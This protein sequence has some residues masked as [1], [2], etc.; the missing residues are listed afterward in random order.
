MRAIEDDPFFRVP[1]GFSPLDLNG[2]V[3]VY[4]RCL[5]HWRQDGATY[6]VTVRQDDAM[7]PDLLRQ[8]R[9]ERQKF[10]LS[11]GGSPTSAEWKRFR[12]QQYETSE[13]TLDDGYG[14]CALRSP[15]LRTIVQQSLLHYHGLECDVGCFVVMPNHW[16]LLIRPHAG[17]SL[18][19]LLRRIK[20]YSAWK[21][22]RTSARQGV[23]WGQESYDRLVRDA[24][25]LIAVMRYIVL[26]G[27]KAGLP[28]TE[29][30]V[31]VNPDWEASGWT[32]DAVIAWP[33]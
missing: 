32:A 15:E 22:N 17:V 25:H 29:F 13:G 1:P 20:G 7:P 24:S 31:W 23:F 9:R 8:L 2:E 12:Q 5:P 6:F 16:H 19:D 3:E 28:S 14:T 30:T 18:E 11:H 33:R 26:N 4:D 21:I 10:L 27:R